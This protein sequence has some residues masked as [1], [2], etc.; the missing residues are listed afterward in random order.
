M[1]GRVSSKL[2]L[3][4]NMYSPG[5]ISKNNLNVCSDTKQIAID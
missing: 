1:A 2:K 5:L 4:A 3:S